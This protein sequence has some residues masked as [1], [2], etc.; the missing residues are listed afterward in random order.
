MSLPIVSFSISQMG[1]ENILAWNINDKSI[2]S[3]W[4]KKGSYQIALVNLTQVFAPN[5]NIAIHP[6]D[7]WNLFYYA[8]NIFS[9]L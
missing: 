7:Y 6:I 1:P 4:T 8:V 9:G 3:I 5:V 2:N